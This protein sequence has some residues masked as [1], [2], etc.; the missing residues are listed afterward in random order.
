MGFYVKSLAIIKQ[1]NKVLGIYD[2]MGNFVLK[3]ILHAWLLELVWGPSDD[4]SCLS[5]WSG[6]VS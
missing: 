5:C 2:L 4:A 6:P 3:K 1:N